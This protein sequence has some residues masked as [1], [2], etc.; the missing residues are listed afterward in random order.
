MGY[1]SFFVNLLM[2]HDTDYLFLTTSKK[3]ID[4]MA[5]ASAESFYIKKAKEMKQNNIDF[6]HIKNIF[7]TMY[8]VEITLFNIDDIK[9]AFECEKLVKENK[10]YRFYPYTI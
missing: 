10:A 5:V 4:S 8:D 6:C 9:D 7:G 3:L 2:K 1:N